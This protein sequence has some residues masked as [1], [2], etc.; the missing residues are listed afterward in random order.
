MSIFSP[1]T[2]TVRVPSVCAFICHA[3]VSTLAWLQCCGVMLTIHNIVKHPMWLDLSGGGVYREQGDCTFYCRVL[4]E[5]EAWFS[6]IVH[7]Q[8]SANYILKRRKYK[9]GKDQK[10]TTTKNRNRKTS[11]TNLL[12]VYSV[13]LCLQM[14]IIVVLCL[15]GI[16][17]YYRF[18]LVK[19]GDRVS[20]VNKSEIGHDFQKNR[21]AHYIHQKVQRNT[22]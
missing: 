6:F 10:A 8:D 9:C 5:I 19:G 17:F 21:H 18:K 3:S 1:I 20:L 14:Q 15:L 7:R 16:L 13:S 12:R 11:C 4:H 2:G 22:V